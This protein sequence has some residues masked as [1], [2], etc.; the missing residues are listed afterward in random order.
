MSNLRPPSPHWGVTPAQVAAALDAVD[1]PGSPAARQ[2]RR[3]FLTS[4]SLPGGG[5]L[6]AEIP[7]NDAR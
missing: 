2:Q 7:S 4:I 1:A 6:P 3:R 5:G